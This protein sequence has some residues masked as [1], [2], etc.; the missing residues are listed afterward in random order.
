[1]MSYNVEQRTHE[2][3]VRAAL[4]ASRADILSLVVGQGFRITFLGI[5]AGIAGSLAIT[6]FM[7]NMLFGVNER[8]TFTFIAVPLLL[9]AVALVAC[10]LPARRA[11]KV[12]P[13]VALRHE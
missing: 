3:G 8:D 1:V 4:G 12:D 9:S 2:I 10:Y 5:F 6:R 7:A 11:A 13:M